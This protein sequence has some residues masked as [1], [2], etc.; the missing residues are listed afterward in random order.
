MRQ[1][2]TPPGSTKAPLGVGKS[3]PAVGGARKIG[4]RPAEPKELR[5]DGA[6]GEPWVAAGEAEAV[7]RDPG[8]V[9]AKAGAQRI[10]D[11]TL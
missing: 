7:G 5:E 9:E 4:A 2:K 1:K 10:R 6:T 8:C 11:R 3:P